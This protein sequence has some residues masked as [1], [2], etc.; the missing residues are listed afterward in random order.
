M[1]TSLRIIT[2][3]II[4]SSGSG[5]GCLV[6]DVK[7]ERKKEKK[8]NKYLGYSSNMSRERKMNKPRALTGNPW[9]TWRK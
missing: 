9:P 1:Y 8:N 7:R 3:Y 2:H 5:G 4:S 6:Y